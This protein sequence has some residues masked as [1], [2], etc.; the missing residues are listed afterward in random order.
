M[1]AIP[2]TVHTDDD[3]KHWF[4]DV[5]VPHREVWV[6]C[7]DED[8]EILGLLVLD[9]DWLDQLYVAP[10]CVGRGIGSTLIGVA[11]RARPRGLQ[12]WTF[13]SNVGAQRFYE[14][15]DFVEVERTEGDNEEGAP[16]IRYA[17]HRP[18]AGDLRS[19]ARA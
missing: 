16:D 13:A 14:R 4:R 8:A 1:P 17:W 2:P 18:S 19:R 11:K 5:V 12:L 10:E 7:E 9:G 3:V 15:H 6:A